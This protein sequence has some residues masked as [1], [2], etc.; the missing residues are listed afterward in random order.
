M[1]DGKVAEAEALQNS[2]LA[3]NAVEQVKA[4]KFD[5]DYINGVPQAREIYVLVE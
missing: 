4:M 1:A 2:G 5:P 3:P